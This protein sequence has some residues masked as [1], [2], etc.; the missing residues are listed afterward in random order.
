[1]AVIA[2]WPCGLSPVTQGKGHIEA[3]G[4][5]G[6]PEVRRRAGKARRHERWRRSSVAGPLPSG[7]G[8]NFHH[9]W[10]FLWF[11]G[12]EW[13]KAQSPMKGFGLDG[14]AGINHEIIYP[15]LRLDSATLCGRD[16]DLA[17]RPSKRALPPAGT[18]GTVKRVTTC[19]YAGYP[20]PQTSRVKRG[21]NMRA[22]PT[23]ADQW[24][25]EAN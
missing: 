19:R 21:R 22:C 2:D 18:T 20:L 9:G 14:M 4:Q 15:Q 24:P 12:L 3:A 10:G 5:Q 8:G 17:G 16:M 11:A 1:M 25:R 6:L 13:K 7:L 23:D